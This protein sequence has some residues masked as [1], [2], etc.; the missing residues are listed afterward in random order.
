MEN[1]GNRIKFQADARTFHFLK[2]VQK[3]Y[4][5]RPASIFGTRGFPP[6]VNE[7]IFGGRTTNTVYRSFTL[8]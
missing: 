4:C 2:S 5:I 3:G 1:P 8:G 7:A 6:G